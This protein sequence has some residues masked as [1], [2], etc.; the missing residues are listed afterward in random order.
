[1]ALDIFQLVRERCLLANINL[2]TEMN[3]D[4]RKAAVD[5]KFEFSSAN[6]LL[7]KLGPDLR[8]TFYRP[9]ETEDA[10]TADHMPH[11]KFPLM[12]P[13][14]WDLEIPRTVLRVHDVD[15]EKHDVVL[16]G[17][18]TNKF[19][20]TMMQGGTVK[21]EFRCQFSKP[22]EDSVAK[23]MRVMNQKVPISLECKD[24]EEK[25]NNFDQV[26]A[27]AKAPQSEAGKALADLFS[28]GAAPDTLPEAVAFLDTASA[29]AMVIDEAAAAAA[30]AA[31]PAKKEPKAKPAVKQAEAP[32]ARPRRTGKAVVAPE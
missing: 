19:K 32:A 6:N 11:L 10:V 12:G 29:D 5:L 21:W 8:A 7:A 20:L 28:G 25:P 23:L 13:I 9:D 22:D 30:V 1:M 14:V 17:G 15:D 26:E 2:R 27:Q 31:A 16:G 4:E 24:E 18:R 3:G